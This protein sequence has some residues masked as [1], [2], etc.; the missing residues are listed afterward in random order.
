MRS[1]FPA[2]A[3]ALA[4]ALPPPTMAAEDS[5]ITVRLCG[6]ANVRLRLPVTPEAPDP[7]DSCGKACHFG[8]RRRA[9]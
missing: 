3:G 6:D 5:A 7:S 2:L 4:L 1:A 8:C 9:A